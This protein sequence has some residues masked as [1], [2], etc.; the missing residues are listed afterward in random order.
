L[1]DIG[2]NIDFD[3]DTW[4][5]DRLIRSAGE[6][7][8]DYTLYFSSIPSEYRDLGKFFSLMEYNEKKAVRTI[9]A[10]LS[11]LTV[12]LKYI[13]EKHET[14]ELS[15]VNKAV[16]NQYELYLKDSSY[17]KSTKEHLF[18]AI[19]N[20]FSIMKGWTEMPLNVPTGR[21]NPFNRTKEERRIAGKLIPEFITKQLD[22]VFRDERIPLYIRTMYWLLRSIPSRVTE[23]CSIKIDC[24]KPSYKGDGNWII[25]IPTWKQ[26][27][28]YK[29]PELRTIHVK[30]EG[31]GKYVMDLVKEQQ[32]ISERLQS[33]LKDKDKGMLFTYT[34]KRFN[35]QIYNKNSEVVY[36]ER[37]IDFTVVANGRS[38]RKW[39]NTICK[40]YRITNKNGEPYSFTSH[41]LRHNG[42]TE[43]FYEGF[44]LIEIRDMTGHK[45]DEMLQT[46]YIHDDPVRIV[47]IQRNVSNQNTPNTDKSPVYFKG[48]ILNMD[49]EQE[50]RILANPR[51]NRLGKLG[52]C[53]DMSNCKPGLYEC[54]DCDLC[55]PDVDDLEYFEEQVI[56]WTRK[57]EQFKNHQFM[58]E[59]AEYNLFLH[60]RMVDKIK[61]ALKSQ[62]ENNNAS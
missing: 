49:K 52:I 18:T 35:G 37:D 19:K 57:V 6:A 25:F 32:Q 5:L 9:K 4:F 47:E 21:K 20:F 8:T 62:E 61:N 44:S 3:D 13:S 29:V 10:D 24:L 54:L 38:V 27:G 12:F 36:H 41:Q 39:F 17:K 28:G 51:A 30:Y 43:R 14:I 53:G 22:V 60:Q 33:H 34:P 56:I 55:I 7:N 46:S 31:H 58:R 42:I 15:Q 45:G 48:R 11:G 50:T 59:N 26:S 1:S 23:V 2:S 40:A 16:I